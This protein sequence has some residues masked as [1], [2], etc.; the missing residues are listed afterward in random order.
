[1]LNFLK[2]V[3]RYFF[4]CSCVYRHSLVVL[5]VS[6]DIMFNAGNDILGI[7]LFK[8]KAGD[9]LVKFDVALRDG[10]NEVVGH[11]R[12]LLSVQALEAIFDEPLTHKL[13]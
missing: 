3:G 5:Q 10:L 6:I 4:G 12:H 2:C 13:F 11:E 8:R 7:G 9:A 1:M